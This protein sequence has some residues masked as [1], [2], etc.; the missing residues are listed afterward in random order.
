ATATAEPNKTATAT[1][2]THEVS[3][4]DLARAKDLVK[5]HF[6]VKEAQRRGELSRG[7]E[8]ARAMVER[9]VGG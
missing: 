4:P 7:L 9:A 5:L 1:T 6:E 8:E 3:D 2:T